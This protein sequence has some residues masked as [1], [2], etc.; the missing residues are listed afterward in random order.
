MSPLRRCLLYG[1]NCSEGGFAVPGT[2]RCPAHSRGWR[3]SAAMVARGGYYQSPGW[4]ERSKR[5]L[6]KFPVCVRCGGKATIADH[7]APIGLGGDPAGKLQSMC[8]RCHNLKSSSEG[9]RAAKAKRAVSRAEP[10]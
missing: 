6:A 1:K 10:K 3:K 5:Q 9:G 2:S 7:L 8:T 4:R